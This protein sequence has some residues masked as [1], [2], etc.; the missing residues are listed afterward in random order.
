M[1]LL[2]EEEEEEGSPVCVPSSIMR[3]VVYL[4]EDGT[5]VKDESGFL[6]LDEMM[7]LDYD[8]ENAG[9][10]GSGNQGSVFKVRKKA[11]DGNVALKISVEYNEPD[12]SPLDTFAKR[13]IAALKAI[14]EA[15]DGAAA[16]SAFFSCLDYYFKIRLSDLLKYTDGVGRRSYIND[17]FLD[18]SNDLERAN[19]RL[20]LS[21]NLRVPED[22][23]S[24]VYFIATRLVEDEDGGDGVSKIGR[25]HV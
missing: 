17:I 22:Q 13:E 9:R 8:F 2:Q 18:I 10:V 3:K 12:E 20:A 5:P 24:S 4:Y 25:A 21:T 23:D 16:C 7:A 14:R 19:V 6:S 1:R 11:S 15:E